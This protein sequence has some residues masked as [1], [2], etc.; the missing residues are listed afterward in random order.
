M[1]AKGTI[2]V[3]D[4]DNV[5]RDGLVGRLTLLGYH[6][7]VIA[8]HLDHYITATRECPVDL[9]VVNVGRSDDA[10]PPVHG[11]E[12]VAYIHAHQRRVQVLALFQL[13]D[14]ELPFRA[15]KAG[16]GSVEDFDHLRP[17][18]LGR[19]VAALLRSDRYANSYY[20]ARIT[21]RPV[22]ATEPVRS[23]RERLE[24]LT[25]VQ[26]K[27]L[28][29]ALQEHYLTNK[30]IGVRLTIKPSTVK[31]HLQNICGKLGCDT[32]KNLVPMAA[33]EGWLPFNSQL[34]QRAGSRTA[35]EKGGAG[36]KP[37]RTDAPQ[38]P[39]SAR[40]LQRLSAGL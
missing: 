35:G 6:V 12:T 25:E 10:L 14:P 28:D 19:L 21:A 40:D 22:P 32:R 15:Y 30:Q 1:D 16:A 36:R 4:C 33:R 7:A 9:A 38:K 3:V 13:P 29:L 5:R 20:E 34:A 27:V 17:A 18:L 24:G 2:A 37:T 8:D 31:T 23:S 39:F 26:L 11:L